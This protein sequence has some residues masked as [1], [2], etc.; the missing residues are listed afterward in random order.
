MPFS[1]SKFVYEFIIWD[2][3]FRA[4]AFPS[5]LKDAYIIFSIIDKKKS[6]LHLSPNPGYTNANSLV[7][8]Q[9][10]TTP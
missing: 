2:I 4:C 10:K 9:R 1:L 8:I 5:S 7:H 6:S 3:N